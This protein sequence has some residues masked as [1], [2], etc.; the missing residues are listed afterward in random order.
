MGFYFT[1]LCLSLLLTISVYLYCWFIVMFKG[2]HQQIDFT[3]P[4]LSC[5]VLSFLQYSFLFFYSSPFNFRTFD[6]V[7]V[8]IIFL[9]SHY[10]HHHHHYHQCD[11]ISSFSLYESCVFFLLH[12]TTPSIIPYCPISL[13]SIFTLLPLSSSCHIIGSWIC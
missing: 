11:L 4:V 10:H 8:I 2:C 12:S 1:I 9:L 7:I 5:P 13:H 3:L 6:I